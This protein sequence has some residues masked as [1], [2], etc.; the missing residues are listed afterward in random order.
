MQDHASDVRRSG[1]Q[2]RTRPE[3]DAA[4][5][6][7]VAA[8]LRVPDVAPEQAI[9]EI[10]ADS[11]NIV[12]IATALESAFGMPVP[13]TVFVRLGS[14]RALGDYIERQLSRAKFVA[15]DSASVQ[16]G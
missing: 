6:D 7:V 4:I 3:I 14:P 12:N 13:L 10:G 1:G 8:E 16:G 11:L 15:C 2:C 5:R 9:A